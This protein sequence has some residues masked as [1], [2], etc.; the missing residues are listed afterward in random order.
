MSPPD[1][2]N[3]PPV[4]LL[5]SSLLVRANEGRTLRAFGHAVVIL[6]DGE[7]TDGSSRPF[8]I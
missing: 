5:A 7:Q 4:S 8:S 6:L 1:V 2:E 3:S